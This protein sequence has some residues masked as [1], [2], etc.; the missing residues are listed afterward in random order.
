MD[1]FSEF[2][3]VRLSE[4]GGLAACTVLGEAIWICLRAKGSGAGGREVECERVCTM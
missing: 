2:V 4:G 3:G 1:G